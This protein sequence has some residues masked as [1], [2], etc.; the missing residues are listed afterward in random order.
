MPEPIYLDHAATT[1]PD[2]AVWQEVTATATRAFG[3]PSSSHQFGKE[4]RKLLEDAREFLRG[5]LLA[6]RVVFTSGGTE[7]DMLGVLG[8]VWRRP[9]GRVLVGAADHPAITALEPMLRRLN[10]KLVYVPVTQD[11]DINPEALFDLLGTDV[12]AVAIL[13][14]HN[15]LG[16]LARVGELASLVRRVAPSAHVHVDLVQAYGKVNFDLDELDVDSAAV[17]GHKLHAPRG[18]GMLALSSTAEL[19]PLM[20]GGGQEEG[21]RGGTEN[22]PGIVGLARAAEAA[23]SDLHR[24]ARHMEALGE[25]LFATLRR[26]NDGVA[27]RLGH[28]ERR[29]PH[30]LSLRLP[31]I[32]G[33]TLQERMAARGVAFSIGAACHAHDGDG[34]MNPVHEAIGLSRKQSREVIRVS[35][36]RF[37]TR[38]D[39]ARASEAFAEE[40]AALR[41]QAP[42]R[43][44]EGREVEGR[45]P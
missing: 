28:P 45:A 15:E 1:P 11:G 3:N 7:A 19:T 38:E 32:V 27:E 6:A 39:V 29:L 2:P 37:T 42:K 22:L 40:I 33:A 9:P 43:P 21:L 5:T 23:F 44:R 34:K 12:R 10:H 35:F 14:G 41:A 25:E 31:G 13:H 16:T 8:A 20:L 30:I 18:V 17:A 36:S 24:N 26:A 4:P